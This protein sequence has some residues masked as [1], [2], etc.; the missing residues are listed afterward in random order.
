MLVTT[1]YL[2]Q[3]SPDELRPAREP[4]E[5]LVVA[6]AVEPSPEFT[7]FLLTAVGGHWHWR[8]KIDWTWS[9]WHAWITRPGFETWVGWYDGTP[10]GY[11]E[12]F[13]VEAADQGTEVEVPSFG[14]LPAFIGR[15]FGGHLLTRVLGEA[16]ALS[17]RWP[18][19]G[20]VRR[21]WL[22][23]CTLDGAPALPNYRARGLRPYAER[24]GEVDVP[25]DATGPWP[26]AEAPRPPVPP[27]GRVG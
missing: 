11:A 16:W 3:T 18:D 17:D 25:A 23:T 24:T 10:V 19:L 21:V 26:G 4:A 14:L 6:R 7:R 12:L 1:T 22:H 9:Q 2:E 5:P 20:P 8:T 27:A 15:G 13:G